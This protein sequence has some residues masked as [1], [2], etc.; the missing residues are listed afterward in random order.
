MKRDIKISLAHCIDNNDLGNQ[1]ANILNDMKS[2][3]D[4]TSANYKVRNKDGKFVGFV[5]IDE[6]I[7]EKIQ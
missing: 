3:K 2:R 4:I 7:S 5:Q 6:A 1:I